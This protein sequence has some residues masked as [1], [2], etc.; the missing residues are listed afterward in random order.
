MHLYKLVHL[1]NGLWA[2]W[3]VA[4]QQKIWKYPLKMTYW[5]YFQGWRPAKTDK[6]HRSEKIQLQTEVM[7][8]KEL[9]S[10]PQCHR[11]MNRN[12]Y[13]IAP[14]AAMIRSHEYIKDIRIG[15]ENL[16]LSFYADDIFVV[17]SHPG[18]LNSICYLYLK[19][20]GS[21]QIIPVS[22]FDFSPLKDQF[23]WK[24]SIKCITCLSIFIPRKSKDTSI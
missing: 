10:V 12:N 20:L 11:G 18:E 21:Y 2:S 6:S 23:N 16:L 5:N 17:S 7:C 3:K 9:S 1:V 14:L 15:K 4:L 19:C 22:S 13:A 8:Q 24:R